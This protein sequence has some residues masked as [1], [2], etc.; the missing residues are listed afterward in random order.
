MPRSNS[1]KWWTPRNK[2]VLAWTCGV[3][4]GY[5]ICG[6]FI[7]PV[8]ARAVAVRELS[9]F[10][11]RPV[12]IRKFQLNPCTLSASIRGILIKDKDALPLASCEE[13]SFNFRL[14]SVFT[15][16]WVFNEI[17]LS[18][19]FLR[20]QVNQDYTLNI[21]DI[22]AKLSVGDRLESSPL[23]KPSSW[24]ITRLRVI[25]GKLSFTDLTTRR[26]F[27]RTV[28][29]LELTATNF[30]T[31]PGHKNAF[32]LSG[33]SDA[34]EQFSWSGSFD[35]SPLRSEGQVALSGFALTGYA[36]LYEDLFRFQ[37]K[38]GVA[39]LHSSYRYEGSAATNLM[40]LTNTSFELKS[41]EM[42]EKDTGRPVM[43]VSDFAVTG[44]SADALARQSEADMVAVTGGRLF[45]RR[46]KDASV[47]AM[48][49]LKPADSAPPAPG[50]ILLLLRA[51]TNLVAL[52]LNTTNL[53]NGAIRE[54]NFT[55]CT[56]HL[57]DLVNPQ[58]VRLDL[59]DIAVQ[60]KNISNRTGTNMTAQVSLRW[61]TNGS[62]RAGLKAGL[63]PPNVEATL[64]LDKLNLLPL[65][66]YLEPY[67]EAFVL[68]S[69][70]G[71][72]GMVRL[73]STGEA[74]PEV[75][76]QGDAWLDGF[77]LAEGTAAESLVQWES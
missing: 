34:G 1:T 61:N 9:K 66:P 36:P 16:A 30:Q 63:A 45:L 38:D 46:N 23:T 55:N 19:L 8:I 26:P 54:L 17:S 31:D 47:N 74:L 52:L 39:S 65:A 43:E 70:V 71:L 25:D 50:G 20:V 11:A 57:E 64:S 12:T 27:K 28:G 32:A 77:S 14:T 58:P 37:I 72:K 29:R 67:L 4:L 44:A 62:V 42:V 76:F 49:L 2:R 53:A 3:L 73:R 10:L 40:S 59:E 5:T 33:I 48:E 60:A 7:F 68:G 13:A 24:R 41:L 75:S 51:M 21:S 18:G 69:K 6:F 35:L 22:L 15:H 56:V